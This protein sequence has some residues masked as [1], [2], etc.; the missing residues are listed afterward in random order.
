MRKKILSEFLETSRRNYT[1]CDFRTVHRVAVPSFARRS[2][3]QPSCWCCWS[4]WTVN[5]TYCFRLLAWCSFQPTL[6]KKD[7]DD[8]QVLFCTK[9]QLWSSLFLYSAFVVI[10]FVFYLASV[11]FSRSWQIFTKRNPNSDNRVWRRGVCTFPLYVYA[12]RAEELNGYPVRE[13]QRMSYWP[14][15]TLRW[16]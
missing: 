4:H 3:L 11:A 13:G 12:V 9:D 8:T 10:I 6:H 14:L 1:T 16:P 15:V 2:F 5:H 7:T